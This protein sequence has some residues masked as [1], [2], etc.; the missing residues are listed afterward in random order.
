MRGSLIAIVG[1]DGSGKSTQ[2][3][4]LYNIL[5]EELTDRKVILD[6]FTT[7]NSGDKKSLRQSI[8]FVKEMQL[9]PSPAE[10]DFIKSIFFIRNRLID[11]FNE[12]DGGSVVIID[13]YIESIYGHLKLFGFEPDLIRKIIDEQRFKPNVYVMLDVPP[14]IAFER[15]K[16]RDKQLKA[17]ESLDNLEKMHIEYKRIVESQGGVFVDGTKD[18]DTVYRA[19]KN[20]ITGVV[21]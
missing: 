8:N 14:N 9:D 13:R 10:F 3:K 16:G 18:E 4:R 20:Q 19:I 17:H 12:I 21:I 2:T 11:F 1:I 7:D 15:I 6:Q 5:K